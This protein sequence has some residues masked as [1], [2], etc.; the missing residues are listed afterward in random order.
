M[1]E[2]MIERAPWQVLVLF[3][4]FTASPWKRNKPFCPTDATLGHTTCS[5]QWN[6]F[7][8]SPRRNI[9]NNWVVLPSL[10]SF[11][12]NPDTSQGWRSPTVWF[13]QHLLLPETSSSAE[14][15]PMC[16]GAVCEMLGWGAICYS[17][18][19]Q[20]KV[21]DTG[22]VVLGLKDPTKDPPRPGLELKFSLGLEDSDSRPPRKSPWPQPHWHHWIR[23]PR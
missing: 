23:Q 4:V 19:T 11:C 15:R 8:S 14:L 18:N 7:L 6:V 10:F 17:S 13:L 5:G 2:W 9:R 16:E 20:L 21:T 22:R 1:N 12:H 3:Q